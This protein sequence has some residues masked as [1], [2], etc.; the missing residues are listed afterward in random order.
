MIITLIYLN[1]E[2]PSRYLTR[3]WS[4]STDMENCEIPTVPGDGWE[5]LS[6]VNQHVMLWHAWRT[7]VLWWLTERHIRSSCVSE[8][9]SAL[10]AL[11]VGL[12]QDAVDLQV[13]HHVCR[14]SQFWR[15]AGADRAAGAHNTL[16]GAAPSCMFWTADAALAVGWLKCRSQH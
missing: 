13:G 9:A 14:P 8:A 2:P 16:T 7:L 3:S 5:E 12:F 15:V 1:D 4:L 6:E 11:E 10:Q